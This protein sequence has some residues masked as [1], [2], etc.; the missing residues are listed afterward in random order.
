MAAEHIT[1]T[2]TVVIRDE[3]HPGLQDNAAVAVRPH[4]ILDSGDDFSV[5]NAERFYIRPGQETKPQSSG[6][7]IRRMLATRG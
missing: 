7:P 3:M 5:R 4:R 6:C 1:M 2:G